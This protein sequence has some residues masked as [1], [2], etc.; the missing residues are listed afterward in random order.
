MINQKQDVLEEGNSVDE[1]P[2]TIIES[3]SDQVDDLKSIKKGRKSSWLMSSMISKKDKSNMEDD[4]FS[5]SQSEVNELM[6]SEIIAGDNSS[7]RSK[8]SFLG[9]GKK[10]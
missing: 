7:K 10:K 1:I 3:V 4:S 2:Q 5:R 6:Q 8:R 9:F